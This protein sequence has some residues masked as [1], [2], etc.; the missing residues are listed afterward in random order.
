MAKRQKEINK[1]PKVQNIVMLGCNARI[2]NFLNGLDEFA[3]K[4][5]R[6]TLVSETEVKLN[7]KD[8]PNLKI[9]VIQGSPLDPANLEVTTR[10]T[11][12]QRAV[13]ER[14]ELKS[15]HVVWIP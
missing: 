15:K 5:T 3:Y 4:G 8:Y 12:Q 13:T 9:K 2:E 1:K 11:A 14:V 6:F 10:C 7:P